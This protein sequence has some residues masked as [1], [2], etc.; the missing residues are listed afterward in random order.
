MGYSENRRCRK[1]SIKPVTTNISPQFLFFPLPAH[2]TEDSKHL[3]L[4]LSLYLSLSLCRDDGS[5]SAA[6]AYHNQLVAGD[7]EAPDDVP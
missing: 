5:D 4:S 3:S 1:Q 7:E 2:A 6:D